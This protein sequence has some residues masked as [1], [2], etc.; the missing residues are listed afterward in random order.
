MERDGA[1]FHLPPGLRGPDPS[2]SPGSYRFVETPA[3]V[4]VGASFACEDTRSDAGERI[5]SYERALRELLART[6]ANAG[7]EIPVRLNAVTEIEWEDYE[8]VE[9]VLDAILARAD[10][11]VGECL[12][13][14]HIWLGMLS[15]MLRAA[16]KA[17]AGPSAKET[18][19]Y[20][21]E[22]T[23]Q[24]GYARVFSLAERAAARPTVKRMLLGTLIGFRRTL[25]PRQWR[26][27]ATLRAT[28][29]N[30]RHWMRLGAL[31]FPGID[32][33]VPWR[34]FEPNPADLAP[35]E[36]QRL[37]RRY[38]R[39]SL[40]R[41]DPILHTDLHLGFC[42]LIL[43]HGLVEWYA[44]A[45]KPL[46]RSDTVGAALGLVERHFVLDPDFGPL[47]L[48]HPAIGDAIHLA[49]NRP[50]FAHTIVK[51]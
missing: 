18:I 15:G 11:P 8:A 27:T 10:R 1:G 42:F 22:R 16:R 13:A 2:V 38:F 25:R 50:H 32:D 41:K 47:F 29:E 44:A 45:L 36:P 6:G 51:G 34:E 28:V 4:F 3:G 21:V 24:D 14:G 5:E 39:H 49:S 31:R 46:G 9:R 43:V 12:I 35:E 40:F 37:L 17:G 26:M 30:L 7:V 23:G 19:R 20:Y 48:H 33:R